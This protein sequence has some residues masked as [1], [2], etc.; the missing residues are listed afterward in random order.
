MR[1]TPRPTALAVAS[2]LATLTVANGAH[3][4]PNRLDGELSVDV[5]DYY[6]RAMPKFDLGDP[7]KITG[8]SVGTGTLPSTGEQ[9]FLAMGFDTAFVF[10]QRLQVPLFGL[11]GA[12]A[13]GQSPRVITSVDGTFVTLK[14]WTSGA[15]TMLFPGIGLRAKARRWS[16]NATMRPVATFLWMSVAYSSGGALDDGQPAVWAGTFGAR[17]HIEACRRLDPESRACLFVEPHVYE[18]GFMNGGS[19]GLRWEFGP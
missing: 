3:A 19:A 13:I 6:L 9:H 15:I 8:R 10:N 5:R 18:F 11:Y 14:P 4:R 16:F 7:T 17:G 12:G 1:A 2:V